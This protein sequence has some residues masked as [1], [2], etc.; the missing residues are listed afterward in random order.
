MGNFR[1][2]FL[3]TESMEHVQ[4]E[5]AR[6]AIGM[7]K[8]RV[9]EITKLLSEAEQPPLDVGVHDADGRDDGAKKKRKKTHKKYGSSQ[10][11]LRTEKKSW[12][13]LLPILYRME[14][15]ARKGEPKHF[16]TPKCIRA[17]NNKLRKALDKCG[18]ANFKVGSLNLL[19]NKYDRSRFASKKRDQ[20][21]L[22]EGSSSADE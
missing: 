20:A 18:V 22:E 21:K 15:P 10:L 5:W 9:A 6:L 16:D 14:E 17:F 3:V 1:P 11:L 19:M 7:V 8:E 2:R 13:Q 4:E 12:K